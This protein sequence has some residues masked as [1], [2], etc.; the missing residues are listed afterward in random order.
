MFITRINAREKILKFEELKG[1][2]MQE[3]ERRSSLKP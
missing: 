1:I 3:E 2:L